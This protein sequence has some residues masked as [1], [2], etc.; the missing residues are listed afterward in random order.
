MGH[1]NRGELQLSAGRFMRGAVTKGHLGSEG[2]F[3]STPDNRFDS[4]SA[5]PSLL[6]HL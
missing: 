5:R 1:L 6:T 3:S 2:T 4:S